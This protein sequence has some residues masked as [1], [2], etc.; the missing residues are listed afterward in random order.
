MSLVCLFWVL[1]VWGFPKL[2]VLIP[3]PYPGFTRR[4]S[5]GPSDWSN[6]TGPPAKWLVLSIHCV[7]TLLSALCVSALLEPS[8]EPTEGG[9]FYD[10]HLIGA[11]T[12]MVLA[13]SS[14]WMGRRQGSWGAGVLGAGGRTGHW[15]SQVAFQLHCVLPRH[16]SLL[17]WGS[18]ILQ[19]PLLFLIC[20][21]SL[22][23]GNYIHILEAT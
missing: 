10:H 15:R 13:V 6:D 16:F 1:S 2:R 21:W 7:L 17:M 11:E 20:S 18:R 9:E 23:I 12:K 14:G 22:V 5:C 4:D 19:V 8:Q 3:G